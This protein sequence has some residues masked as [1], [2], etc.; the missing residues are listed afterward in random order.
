MDK[1]TKGILTFTAA[2]LIIVLVLVFA[3]RGQLF[4]VSQGNCD[5]AVG[6]GLGLTSTC[7]GHGYDIV[8]TDYEVAPSPANFAL[9]VGTTQ[10]IAS[11]SFEILQFGGGTVIALGGAQQ[12]LYQSTLGTT[13]GQSAFILSVPISTLPIG[14]GSSTTYYAKELDLN[15]ATYPQSYYQIQIENMTNQCGNCYP[16]GYQIMLIVSKITQYTPATT[17][18]TTAISTS[19]TVSGA[20]TTITG[21]GGGSGSGP[22]T[23]TTT[24]M[25]WANKN[26]EL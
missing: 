14:G 6:P 13:Y 23:S 20:S 15:N 9:V 10:D 24:I 21:G 25:P 4:S 3:L 17:T 2:A 18:T 5:Y 12:G 22:T 19:T 11:S 1:R 16:N 8:L 26:S 7:F